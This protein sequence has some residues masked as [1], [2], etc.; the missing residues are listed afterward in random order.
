MSKNRQKE[1]VSFVVSEKIHE[2]KYRL[3]HNI[4]FHIQNLYR[5]RSLNSLSQMAQ[6]WL[7]AEP[8]KES[9]TECI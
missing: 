5:I 4:Q 8:K 6:Q 3:K 7:I 2:K 9:N 1:R